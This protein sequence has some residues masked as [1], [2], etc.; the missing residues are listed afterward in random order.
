[1]EKELRELLLTLI[2]PSRSDVGCINY[3]LHQSIEDPAT[4]L[5]YENW[6]S[7]E[8]L[9]KHA[10]AAHSQAFRAKASE[11]LAEPPEVTLLKMIS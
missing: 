9:D 5:F 7:R 10:A 2:E 8:H 1:M 6:S 4:F 3:D 11:L